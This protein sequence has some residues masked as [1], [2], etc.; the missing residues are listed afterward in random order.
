MGK[1]EKKRHNLRKE[2]DMRGKMSQEK[3]THERV[4]LLIR[5]H[6][7]SKSRPDLFLRGLV[8]FCGFF[9]YVPFLSFV[10]ASKVLFKTAIPIPVVVLLVV[11][12]INF[13]TVG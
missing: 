4:C 10:I 2:M 6:Y 1:I 3:K 13:A 12:I 11:V 7:C 9:F 8:F 5:R